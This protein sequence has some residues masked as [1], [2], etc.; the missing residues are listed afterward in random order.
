M[1]L[2]SIAAFAPVALLVATA[3]HAAPAGSQPRPLC[4]A[5]IPAACQ[6]LAVVPPSATTTAPEFAARISVAN[7]MANHAL[8]QLTLQPTNASLDELDTAARPSIDMLDD[9]IA[10]GDP[11]NRDVA[12]QAK[13]DL[14]NGMAI[15][16]RRVTNDPRDKHGLEARLASW[17]RGAKAA[18]AQGESCRPP[19]QACLETC[20]APRIAS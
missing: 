16:I 3:A 5:D 11:H 6:A 1:R 15:R 2:V 19:I 8:G 7:C 13:A 10:H 9:V 17:Q 20:P 12:Q 4:T 14:L 18:L